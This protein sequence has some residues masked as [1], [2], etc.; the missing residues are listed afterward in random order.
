MRHGPWWVLT[1]VVLAVACGDAPLTYKQ[2][3]VGSYATGAHQLKIGEAVTSVEGATVTRDFFTAAGALPLLGRFFVDGDHAPAAPP[4][5]VLSH[6]LWTE[7]FASSPSII[8]ENIELD[9]RHAIVVGVAP[10]DF[11]VPEGARLWTPKDRED[12]KRSLGDLNKAAYG[13]NRS[14]SRG[15]D[16]GPDVRGSRL[17]PGRPEQTRFRARS[18]TGALDGGQ[19]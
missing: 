10:R 4:V 12:G 13:Q 2:P 14:T 18:T 3:P 19:T 16:R 11:R 15:N 9:G 1:A 5:V 6:D 7:R 8:G 17:G